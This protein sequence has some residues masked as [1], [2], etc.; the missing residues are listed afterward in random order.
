MQCAGSLGGTPLSSL[1]LALSKGRL[2]ADSLADL[3]SQTM[4]RQAGKA[5]ARLGAAG[6]ALVSSVAI[7]AAPPAA[8][9]P[10][11]TAASRCLQLSKHNV[12]LEARLFR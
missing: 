4:L 2:H 5:L 12:G 8:A 11:L 7:A 3:R 1:A 9:V 10:A 6:P